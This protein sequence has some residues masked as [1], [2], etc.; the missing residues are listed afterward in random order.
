MAVYESYVT[1]IC[2]PDG[3]WPNGLIYYKI[4]DLKSDKLK[5]KVLK[6]I[7]EFNK[8]TIHCIFTPASK[9]QKYFVK[10]IR[11]DTKNPWSHVGC[12][13]LD[14]Q[15]ISLPEKYPNSSAT[16]KVTCILHEMMHTVG[17][18]HE[19]CRN[20][21][22][23][24]CQ[25]LPDKV[26]D[27]NYQKRGYDIGSYD[28]RSV[29]HYGDQAGI[30]A[31]NK[32]LANLADNGESLSQGDR[33]AIRLLYSPPGTH[34]GEWHMKCPSTCTEKSCGCGNCG[35]IRGGIHCGYAGTEGHWTCCMSEERNSE[36][37]IDHTGV[38]HAECQ[39]FNECRTG[40]H[41]CG[42]C[43]GGCRH[44]GIKAHWSCCNE[45]D[46][47][48]KCKLP[49]KKK[50]PKKEEDTQVPDLITVNVGK[51]VL[52]LEKKKEEE[53]IKKEEIKRKIELL[54]SKKEEKIV[55]LDKQ[56][57]MESLI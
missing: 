32:E 40:F 52:I 45:E 6:A 46:F 37:K 56:N 41:P 44:I 16:L 50:L 55:V 15:I 8:V 47:N 35:L 18:G 28:Y 12:Q 1:G 54:E 10:F 2:F 13:Y 19:H 36:C 27:H 57:D 7:D 49:L 48:A 51:D 31:S 24:H 20:D 33:D 30:K 9:D 4:D 17:F 39:K 23:F 42:N 38:W 5:K 14:G 34:H 26:N 53:E 43:G 3:M 11:D 29:M 21:R 22:D 25:V